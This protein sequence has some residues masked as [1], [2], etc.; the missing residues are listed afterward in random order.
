MKKSKNPSVRIKR[1]IKELQNKSN[2]WNIGNVVLELI[3]S[4]GIESMKEAIEEADKDANH[5]IPL[6]MFTESIIIIEKH[7]T[8]S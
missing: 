2:S 6:N 5:F 3:I 1:A 7:I 4:K 8:K